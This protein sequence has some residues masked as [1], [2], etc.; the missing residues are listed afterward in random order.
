MY[1]CFVLHSLAI[2]NINLLWLI[3]CLM[4]HELLPLGVRGSALIKVIILCLT[5]I[6]LF[7]LIKDLHQLFYLNKLNLKINLCLQNPTSLIPILCFLSIHYP[8]YFH[9]N[10]HL[11]KKKKKKIF[12]P[13]CMNLNK[14]NPC[15]TPCKKRHSKTD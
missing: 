9:P 4:M 7:F 15:K 2:T 13:F 11:W 14:T 10:V 5:I 6:M 8:L 1:F 12:H 3:F